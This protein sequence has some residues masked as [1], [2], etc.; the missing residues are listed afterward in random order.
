MTACAATRLMAKGI[1]PALGTQ[2]GIGTGLEIVFLVMSRR[3]MLEVITRH[4]FR[5]RVTR[6]AL[7]AVTT[8][9][10]RAGCAVLR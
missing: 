9:A 2:M 6:A 5:G 10:L 3:L 7:R 1:D 8:R 4:P